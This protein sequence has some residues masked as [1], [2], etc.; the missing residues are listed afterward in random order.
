MIK[1]FFENVGIGIVV[2]K[3]LGEVKGA[4]T[5]EEE[6]EECVSRYHDGILCC[7]AIYFVT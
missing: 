3:A 5:V 7:I 4:E 6:D 2:G 1:F